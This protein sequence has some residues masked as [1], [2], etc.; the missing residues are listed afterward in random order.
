MNALVGHT[1]FVGSNIFASGGIDVGYNSKNIKDAFGTKPELLI[2]SGVRAEKFLANRSPEKDMEMMIQAEKNI[3]LIKPEKLVLI[4]TVDVFAEPVGVD[5]DSPITEQGLC[6]YGLN[7]Y[8]LEQWV[9]ENY[10]DALIVRLPA[11]FGR[12]LKKNF[13]YDMINIV[14]SMLNPEKYR[15]LAER[16]EM[17]ARSYLPADNGFYKLSVGEGDKA[18]LKER[19]ISIGFTAL[20]FTDSRSVFQ[21][22]P[23]DRL[24]NDIL[25]ALDSGLTLLHTATEPVSA[26]E[27]YN[28]VTDKSF[29]NELKK[30][31]PYYNYFTKYSSLFGGEEGYILL[32]EMVLRKIKKYYNTF[33]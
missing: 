2:Y 3:E 7:R 16:D 15:E 30:Y 22:Y 29:T 20:D 12:N 25:T 14:P 33:V 32:K 31:P 28:Y 26:G 13:L 24:W 23:L 9:R 1:G 17:I 5:E 18:E 6:A 4:S 8:R 11:L 27:I 21:F 10:H 19:F